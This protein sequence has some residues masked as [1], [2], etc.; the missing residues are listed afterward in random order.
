MDENIS[1]WWVRASLSALYWSARLL[2]LLAKISSV[3]HGLAAPWARGISP[4]HVSHRRGGLPL[5]H[6]GSHF[7]GGGAP[8]PLRTPSDCG[9]F[10]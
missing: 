10:R 2:S 8:V 1:E 6:Q 9:H 3:A 4:T 5:G 7:S